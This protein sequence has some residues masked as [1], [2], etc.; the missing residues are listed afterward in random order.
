MKYSIVLFLFISCNTSNSIFV[1]KY[2]TQKSSEIDKFFSFVFDRCFIL[3]VELEL[4]KDSTFIVSSCSNIASG[5]WVVKKDTLFLN[6]LSNEIYIDNIKGFKKV[7]NLIEVKNKSEYFLIKK[8]NLI[9]HNKTQ[10]EICTTK[11][12]FVN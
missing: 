4:K 3:G 8:N 6:Y 2:E 9:Q 5:N 12:Y 11:L 7:E 1:G 10:N